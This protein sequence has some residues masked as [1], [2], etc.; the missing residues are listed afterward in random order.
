MNGGQRP[1]GV[2]LEKLLKAGV[3]PSAARSRIMAAI[4]SRNTSPEVALRRMLH[5]RGLRFRLKAKNLPCKPDIIF[6]S[7]R[8]AVFVHGCFWHQHDGCKYAR[9]PKSRIEFWA[10]KFRRN[11]HRDARNIATLQEC[12]WT[13]IVVWDCELKD[14]L[15][16]I[17]IASHVEGLVRG[18]PNT[19]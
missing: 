6:P 11:R 13:P 16:V 7:Q 15:R 3:P 9:I 14:E 12:G 4:R 2:S 19:A 17:E 18:N 1:Q 5:Q 10:E 8:L